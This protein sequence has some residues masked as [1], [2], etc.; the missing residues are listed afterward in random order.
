MDVMTSGIV[1]AAPRNRCVGTFSLC[2]SLVLGARSLTTSVTLAV[3]RDSLY[4]TMSL[5]ES[6]VTEPHNKIL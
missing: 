6:S 5:W 2:K 3:A 4:W 1:L